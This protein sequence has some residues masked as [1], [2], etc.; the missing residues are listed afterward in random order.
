ME[1]AEQTSIMRLARTVADLEGEDRIL[2]EHLAEA[3]NCRVLD[4]ERL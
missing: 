2:I 4:R 1:Q 3:V